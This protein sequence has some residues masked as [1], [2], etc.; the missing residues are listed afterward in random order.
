MPWIHRAIGG[1]V[2]RWGNHREGDWG[3]EAQSTQ[4]VANGRA[5]Y[6]RYTTDIPLAT[7]SRAEDRF[8]GRELIWR[9][10]LIGYG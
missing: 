7:P 10:S 3:A 4:C 8:Q 2:Y 9:E 1:R 6:T 5:M